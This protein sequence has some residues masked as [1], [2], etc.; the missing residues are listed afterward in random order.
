MRWLARLNAQHVECS[1]FP[2]CAPKGYSLQRIQR[3]SLNAQEISTISGSP[4]SVAQGPAIGAA[5]FVPLCDRMSL[6]DRKEWHAQAP[7]CTIDPI[8][9]PW[10]LNPK[11]ACAGPACALAEAPRCT[12]MPAVDWRR[13]HLSILFVDRYHTLYPIPYY[14]NP[15]T[16]SPCAASRT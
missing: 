14:P 12:T 6:F 11:H 8:R 1:L 4:P 13:Y 7:P 2:Y 9:A 10:V 15:I 16:Q 3:V 5:I